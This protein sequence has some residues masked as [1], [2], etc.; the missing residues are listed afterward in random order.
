[1]NDIRDERGFQKRIPYRNNKITQNAKGR[2]CEANFSGCNY[3]PKTVV[4]CHL[5][6]S[7][8]GKGMSQKADDF[9]GFFGC[10]ACHDLYDGRR[11]N[12]VLEDKEVLRAVIKTIRTLIDAGILK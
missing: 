4:F 8:A 9:A 2:N 3:N 5:N 7:Y 10:S 11:K 6:E 12:H 1:M